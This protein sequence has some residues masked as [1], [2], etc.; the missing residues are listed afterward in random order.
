V[1]LRSGPWLRLAA[2]L[3]CAAGLFFSLDSALFRTRLY[4][5]NLEPDSYAGR[6]MRAVSNLERRPRDPARDIAVLGDSRIAEGFAAAV[7]RQLA[8]QYVWI[9]SS[10][11]GTGPR[12]WYYLLREVDPDADRFRA[13]VLTVNR[14]EDDDEARDP[15]EYA[16]DLR[17]TAPLLRWTDAAQFVQSF[18]PEGR[19]DALRVSLLRGLAFKNDVQQF[20]ANP[21]SRIDRAQFERLNREGFNDRYVGN[22]RS[23]A[24][25]MVDRE[26]RTVS[27][28]AGFR[29]DERKAFADSLFHDPWP[30]TGAMAQ[31]RRR[32]FGRILARY[33]NSKTA[34][35]FCRIPSAPWPQPAVQHTSVVRDLAREYRARLLPEEPFTAIE[36]P[37]NFFD[38]VHPNAQ[39]RALLT[40]ALV[41][42]IAAQIGRL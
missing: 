8:P 28:P 29:E 1:E 10:V 13:I 4:L 3:G 15:A 16:F 32:W 17:S 27:V 36:S 40:R 23:M 5:T 14:Y 7:A 35:F 33:R 22:P 41:T 34:I 30:Q 26:K 25:V 24:G 38:Q 2:L 9:N 19:W 11:P 18:P 37:E 21:V 20:L 12:V 31:F 42:Q 6:V 39:G